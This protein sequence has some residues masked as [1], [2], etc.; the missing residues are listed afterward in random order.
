MRTISPK[1][2]H[3]K[4]SK[5]LK[6]NGGPR[7]ATSATKLRTYS[8]PN[9]PARP[10]GRVG[11]NPFWRSHRGS[12]ASLEPV[13]VL[14]LS[15][16]ATQAFIQFDPDNLPHEWRTQHCSDGL[17]WGNFVNTFDGENAGLM[18]DTMVLEYVRIRGFDADGNAVTDFSNALFVPLSA[19]VLSGVQ[20]TSVLN[21]TWDGELPDPARWNIWQSTDDGATFFLVE[22]YWAA[23]SA[24]TFSPDGGSEI[25]FVVG[26][27]ANGKE[28]TVR[29]NQIC[30]DECSP[31]L[32]PAQGFTGYCYNSPEYTTID[33]GSTVVAA[34][35][36]GGNGTYTFSG[37]Q[38]W[39]ENGDWLFPSN[40][41]DQ[42]PVWQICLQYNTDIFWSDSWNPTDPSGTYNR[43]YNS[44]P[45]VSVGAIST[46]YHPATSE[47]RFSWTDNSGGTVTFR[48][49][50]LSDGIP[51]L[52]WEGTG[53]ST[54]MTRPEFTAGQYSFYAVVDGN[55]IQLGQINL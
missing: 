54:V 51:I 6:R 17:S 21:W 10:S 5:L 8:P 32:P 37:G 55:E 30:P 36:S 7:P 49:R 41:N 40:D 38:A 24:R 48:I 34:D 52:A 44:G 28:I 14:V 20:E 13:P 42:N 23:G 31:P 22:D 46:T 25:Y 3:A 18:V 15:E 16:D 26:V 19:P 45:T 43:R 4:K 12:N 35:G 1:S 47:D 9:G 33:D 39:N 11:F 50:A 27:D 53:N 2:G 29:S